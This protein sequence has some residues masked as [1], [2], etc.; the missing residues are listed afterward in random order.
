MVIKKVGIELVTSTEYRFNQFCLNCPDW[1]RSNTRP[2]GRCISFG[3]ANHQ[4]VHK[5]FVLITIVVEIAISATD[6]I[7]DLII[8]TSLVLGVTILFCLKH[9]LSI[10]R[11]IYMLSYIIG[12]CRM[13]PNLG[14]LMEHSKI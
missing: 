2:V 1:H 6:L 13:M 12:H 4:S 9:N 10:A 8:G 3:H 11:G 5:V 7:T 14:T